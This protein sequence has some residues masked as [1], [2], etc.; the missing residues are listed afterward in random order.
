MPKKTGKKRK[1]EV[2]IK[3]GDFVYIDYIGIIKETNEIFDTS[4]ES[5][6]KKA[7]I[8]SESQ[9]YEPQLVIVG[10]KWVVEGLDESLIGRKKGEEYE[11]EVPPEKGYGRRDSRKIVTTTL[12]KLRR[13]GLEGDVRPGMVIEVNGVPAIV[14][15]VVSGRVMLDFNPPLAGK[16]LIYKVW[17]RGILKDKLDKIKALIKRHNSELAEKSVVSL[18]NNLLE[19]NFGSLMLD[20]PRFNV[21]KKNI[22]DDILRYIE[23]IKGIRF[24]EEIFKEKLESTQPQQE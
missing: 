18:K 5:E 24:I 8:Y 13:S 9:V 16:T 12:R 15:A 3:K 2:G 7:G 22:A 11:V 6:A 21:Y 1:R 14:K 19:I 10:E 17:I 23:G 4:I 20:N